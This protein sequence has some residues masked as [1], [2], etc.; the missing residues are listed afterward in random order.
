MDSH[1]TRSIEGRA[2]KSEGIET[3]SFNL[4]SRARLDT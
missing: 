2:R 1:S 4:V 3:N